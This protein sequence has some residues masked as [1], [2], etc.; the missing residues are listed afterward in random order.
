MDSLN[1]ALCSSVQGRPTRSGGCHL[2]L[3][4][5]PSLKQK[6]SSEEE[7]TSTR[8]ICSRNAAASNASSPST[9]AAICSSKSSRRLGESQLLCSAHR[10]W[11]TLLP[12]LQFRVALRK[13]QPQDTHFIF[14]VKQDAPMGFVPFLR[15]FM[16]T[17]ARRSGVQQSRCPVF[18]QSFVT[19]LPSAM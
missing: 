7:S 2:R 15:R 10:Q 3:T 1:F 12:S 6:Q 18:R 13:L 8:P 9:S 17:S 4:I 19:T 14:P 16:D 5:L 11:L